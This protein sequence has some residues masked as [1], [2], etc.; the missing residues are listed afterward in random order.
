MLP[1]VAR[2]L[3]IDL[4]WPVDG[5]SLI[6]GDPPRPEKKFFFNAATMTATFKP[7]E[8]WASRD[9]AARRQ[10][11]IFGLDKWP[12]FTRAG[13]SRSRRARRRVIRRHQGRSTEYAWRSTAGMR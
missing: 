10:A 1:T 3:G 2:V 7:D 13:I 5:R 4:P 9:Q 12:A 6:G 11:D 8:L